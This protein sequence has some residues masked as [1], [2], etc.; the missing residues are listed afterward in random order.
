MG[1]LMAFQAFERKR[2][3][4]G[5]PGVSISKY[6]NFI[7]NSAVVD[8]LFKK[9]RYVKVYWDSD[10]QQIGFKPL[11]KPEKFAYSINYSPKGG[12][13]SFSGT[14]FLKSIG[15]NYKETASF[16][17]TWSEKDGLVVISVKID[18]KGGK[19]V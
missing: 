13:G 4:G 8:Q 11:E 15:F 18:A 3:H 5:E 14:A 12:V 6:G 19:K 17:A 7:I 1:G 10:H 9:R 16:P 2:E